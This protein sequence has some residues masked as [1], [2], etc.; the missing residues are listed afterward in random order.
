MTGFDI[1]AVIDGIVAYASQNYILL[2]AGFALLVLFSSKGIFGRIRAGIEK[3]LTDNWQLTLLASTGIALSLASAYTTWD[4]LRNFTRA[5]LLSV[6]ISFGIQGVMLIVAWLIGESFAVGMSQRTSDGRRLRLADATIGMLLGVA[7]VGIVFYWILH[8][9]NAVSLTKHAGLQT[10]W[11]KFADVSVYFLLALV[12]MGMIAFGSRRGGEISTPYVQSVRLIVKNA[13]LWVMFLASMSASVFFSFDSHFNAIFPAEQRARA[14]EIRTTSQMGGVVADIGALTQKRQIEEAESLF[15]TE[16]WKAYDKQLSSLAQASQGAQGEIERFFVQQMEERRRAINEQQERIATSQ[17]GQAGL[18]NR[19][20]SLT[21]ELSRLK[22]ERPSLAAEYAQHKSELDAKAKEIDAKRVDALA[23]DRGV[24]GTLKHGKGPVYRQRMAELATLQDQYKVKQER[25]KDAQRRLVTVETRVA[26][27][28]RELSTIDGDLAKL[29]GEADTAEQRIKASLAVNAEDEGSKL[30][31]ARVL[32][33]FERARTAFRQQPDTERLGALQQ[34]C[35]N[36]LNAMSSTQATKERVRAID[37]DPKQAAEAA[38]RVFA[39]NA[40]LVAF[41]NNCAGGDKI[42]RHTTT[43]ALLG[44][45]RKCLQDSG[46]ISKDSAEIGA[47]LA[48]ID[49]NRDDKA[50]RF[51]VT[52]NAFLDGNRL[53]YLSLILAIGVDALVFMSGLFGAQ[54]LRSPLSDVPS[55][56]ARSAHQLQAIIEAALL[57]NTFNKARLTRE[58]MHPM[59]PVDGFTNIVRLSELDPESASQVRDVLNAGATIGAVRHTSRAGTYLVRAE[60]YEFLCQVIQKELKTKPA[61]TKRGL[62]L[63]ELETRM[64]EALL[65][66]VR[67]TADAV[68]QHLHPIDEKNGF[69]SEIFMSEVEPE[70]VRPVRNVLTAG[71]SLRVVQRDRSDRDRYY[72]H[73]EL[74]KTLARIRAR[75]LLTESSGDGRIAYGGQL[76]DARPAIADGRVGLNGNGAE[77]RLLGSRAMD[78]EA[79]L[80]RSDD[81]LRAMFQ[82]SI[83]QALGLSVSSLFAVAEPEIAGEAIAAA[84]ALKRIAR[85]H[86]GLSSELKLIEA[87]NRRVL[88]QAESM[89]AE[90]HANDPRV[91]EILQEVVGEIGQRLPAMMLLP[92][93]G[94]MDRLVAALEDGQSENRLSDD[95]EILLVK[96]SKLRKEIKQM[97]LADAGQWRLITRHMDELNKAG[98]MPH[99]A[100]D[101][102]TPTKH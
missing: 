92:E 12:L 95:E 61:E 100:G 15:E 54:A 77:Q 48:S 88:E 13:V 70:H 64:T 52:W 23:E 55:P 51:V 94:L 102:S 96:L 97:N 68:L 98:P 16:G 6:A 101:G 46:L 57:P 81:S 60:L 82:D 31:P 80:A 58:A 42:A 73:A 59:E 27:L 9:Y 36:L 47:R 33:A 30:D 20:I 45:G 79:D 24:E 19:K 84:S 72:L 4:G 91:R 7:L 5:P 43:D 71:S 40:G 26:Q 90:S 34:Q 62:E 53:A 63:N 1:K 87:D 86:L 10:D 76:G 66:D 37:C 21:E 78:R 32:P 75:A 18:A 50:H 44:F 39:L 25:T 69:T 29:K 38:A 83:M 22:A 93:G 67:E 35:S 17:S 2:L 56:K 65:P 85:A 8:Q 14:A 3:A 74:Y 99:Q 11:V 49:M 89:L 28:E 41:H